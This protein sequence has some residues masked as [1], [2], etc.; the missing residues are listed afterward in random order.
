MTKGRRG[1]TVKLLRHK[2]QML[3]GQGSSGHEFAENDSSSDDFGSDDS[4]SG[5]HSEQ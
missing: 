4:V 2:S 5:Y 1:R 3:P